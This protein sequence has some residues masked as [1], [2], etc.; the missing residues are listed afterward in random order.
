M[1][2]YSHYQK[3]ITPPTST[4]HGW[5][6][7][8]VNDALLYSFRS[9]RY[10]T[11]NFPSNLHYHD[12]YELIVIEEGDIEYIC[13]SHIY[14]PRKGDIILIPPRK[15]HMSCINAEETRY[16]RHVFYFYPHAFDAYDGAA[17]FT[18]TQQVE[19]G[20]LFTLSEMQKQKAATLLNDLHTALAAQGGTPERALGIGYMLQLFYL[21]NGA[22]GESR[23]AVQKLPEGI[24]R[25]KNYIDEHYKSIRSVSEI[26]KQFFYSREHA[27]RL[28]K[29]YF[30]ITVSDYL[31]RRR[32]LESQ[33][34]IADG[35]SITGAALAVGFNSLSAFIR[36]FR[37]VSGVSPSEYRKTLR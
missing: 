30:D 2:L 9:T 22:V 11:G 32:I 23:T 1:Q 17:L 28:F 20:A 25:L 34:L 6:N 7:Y 36:G 16:T 18:F 27:S 13:E 4:A 5:R 19:N 29:R 33:R 8:S 12:Y 35:I 10:T 37:A 15:F 26:A 14:S 31:L 3:S 24:L 21:L